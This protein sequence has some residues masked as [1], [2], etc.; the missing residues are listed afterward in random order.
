[1][2]HKHVNVGTMAWRMNPARL[3]RRETLRLYLS[4]KWEDMN[5]H[6]DELSGFVFGLQTSALVSLSV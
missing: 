6:E 1:M 4:A 2:R 3:A 5:Y